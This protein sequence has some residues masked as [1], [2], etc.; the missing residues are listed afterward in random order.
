MYSNNKEYRQVLRD[1]FQMKC[2]P[3]EHPEHMDEETLDEY[4]Y[5]PRAVQQGMN[6]IYEKTKHIPAFY[7]LY[8]TAAAL[9]FSTDVETG[10]AVLLSYHYFT[11]F[12]HLYKCFN[13]MNQSSTPQELNDQ[14]ETTAEYQQLWNLITKK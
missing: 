8:E 9:M 10:L 13:D 1:F 4:T 14:I 6:D 5:D 11:S 2:E 7:H 12:Y 3:I